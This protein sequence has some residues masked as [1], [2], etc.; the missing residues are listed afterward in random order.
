M[1]YNLDRVCPSNQIFRYTRS[2]TPKHVQ[3]VCGVYL[4]TCHLGKAASFEENSQRS[5]PLATGVRFDLP[6][7][8]ISNL[9]L[10]KRTRYRSTNWTE[11]LEYAYY[12]IV[13]SIS[14]NFAVAKIAIAKKACLELPRKIAFAKKVLGLVGYVSCVHCLRY[15]IQ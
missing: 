4:R 2:N 12:D 5:E 11:Y 13:I 15:S 7:I 14:T 10:L 8:W 1:Y 3:R 6:E 9:L